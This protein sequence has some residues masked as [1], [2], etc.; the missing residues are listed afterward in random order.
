MFLWLFIIIIAFYILKIICR[1]ATGPSVDKI[2]GT[3][4]EI[5]TFNK[6][7]RNSSALN[8][9]NEYNRIQDFC[10]NIGTSEVS[11]SAFKA[12]IKDTSSCTLAIIWS[13]K[14]TNHACVAKKYCTPS[15]SCDHWN[16][17][18]DKHLRVQ[19]AFTPCLGA[20][21]LL[22]DSE[23]SHIYFLPLSLCLNEGNGENDRF[24]HM[25]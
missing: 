20:L 25:H 24:F 21:L 11:L 13:D 18:C 17:I 23:P 1:S 16:C 19:R 8:I 15:S 7:Y 2:N 3:S 9:D 14:T 6:D 12:K 4:R 10:R 5:R 22:E